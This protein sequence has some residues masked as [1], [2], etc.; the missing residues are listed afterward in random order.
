MLF[1]TMVF[2]TFRVLTTMPFGNTDAISVTFF[3]LVVGLLSDYPNNNLLVSSFQAIDGT[4]IDKKCPFTGNVSIR[5][6]I[7]S[8]KNTISS[9]PAHLPFLFAVHNLCRFK[10]K[11][12]TVFGRSS[13]IFF[14][15]QFNL[16][17]VKRCESN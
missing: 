1:L 3:F 7:L 12:V 4:Y 6:R 16:E 14:F 8:G 5:G 17:A 15:L 2:Q 11:P 10:I 9:K 13:E